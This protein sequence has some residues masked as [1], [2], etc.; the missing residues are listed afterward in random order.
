MPKAARWIGKGL[1]IFLPVVLTG[2]GFWA[3]LPRAT[4]GIEGPNTISEIRQ[5]QLGG[6]NLT[7]LIRDQN[8]KNPV[9]L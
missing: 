8:R 1:L 3:L 6:F 5:I 9:I 4:S 7:V 2:L